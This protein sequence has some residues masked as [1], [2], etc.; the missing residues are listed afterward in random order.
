MSAAPASCRCAERSFNLWRGDSWCAL[1]ELLRQPENELFYG[2]ITGLPS[3][4]RLPRRDGL[5]RD[6]ATA[7]ARQ[8]L[9]RVLAPWP[10]KSSSPPG[11]TS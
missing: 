3:L 1:S 6:L 5:L 8:L 7:L 11:R 2:R 4:P 10:W 9:A